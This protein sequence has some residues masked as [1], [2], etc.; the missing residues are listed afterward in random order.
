MLPASFAFARKLFGCLLQVPEI[1]VLGKVFY[2]LPS[3]NFELLIFK[4]CAIIRLFL[5]GIAG[6]WQYIAFIE[7]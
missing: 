4:P 6:V 7:L 1:L 3:L 5:G 2:M